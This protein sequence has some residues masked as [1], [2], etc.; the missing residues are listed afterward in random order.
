MTLFLE[1][2]LKTVCFVPNRFTF[3]KGVQSCVFLHKMTLFWQMLLRQV[4][5]AKIA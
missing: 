4:V 3:A 5:L 1:N 2:L